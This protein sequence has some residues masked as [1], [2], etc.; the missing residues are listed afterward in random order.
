MGTMCLCCLGYSST[1]SGVIIFWNIGKWSFYNKY[2]TPGL[3]RQ[4][5]RYGLCQSINDPDLNVYQ[6]LLKDLSQ[7]EHRNPIPD[8][9]FTH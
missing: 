8:F 2:R 6:L 7:M 1:E 9:L 3:I 5:R 4:I